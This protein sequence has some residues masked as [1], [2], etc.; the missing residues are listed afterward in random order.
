MGDYDRLER[1]EIKL[2]SLTETINK[3]AVVE[4]RL[5]DFIQANSDAT[6]KIDS[7]RNDSNFMQIQVAVHEAKIQALTRITW[8]IGTAVSLGIVG[9]I[10]KLIGIV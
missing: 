4:A 3:L 6:N 5:S 10:M 7:L 1:I 8:T 2:D 9:A